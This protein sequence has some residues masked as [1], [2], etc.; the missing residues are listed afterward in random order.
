MLCQILRVI[1][2]TIYSWGTCCPK[3]WGRQSLLACQM[4]ERAL[5]SLYYVE[6]EAG[7]NLKENGVQV[8]SQYIIIVT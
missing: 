7:Q 6:I 4:Y 2:G 1:L 8:Y 3:K 5:A